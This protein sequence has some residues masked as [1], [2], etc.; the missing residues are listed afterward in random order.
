MNIPQTLWEYH[1]NAEYS[2]GDISNEV[3]PGAN[4]VRKT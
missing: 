1:K 4:D 2:V 3:V